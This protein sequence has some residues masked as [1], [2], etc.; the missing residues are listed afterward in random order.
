MKINFG[1]LSPLNKASQVNMDAERYGA[2]AE[3]GAGQEVARHFFQAGKASQTIAKTMSA[4]DMI[5]SDEI[6]GKEKNGRYVCESRL[7]K[8]LSKEYDLLEKRLSASRGEKTKFFAF[9]NT[10]AT[11]SSETPRCHGWMGVRFQN[12]ARGAFNDIVLHV[13]MMDPYRLQQQEALGTLGV[14]LIYA[15]FYGIQKAENFLSLLTENLKAGQIRIDVIKFRG[16]DLVSFDNQKLNLELV[17]KGLSEC[18]LFNPKMDVLNVSD[19]IYGKSV[20]VQRGHYKPPTITHVEVFKKGFEHFRKSLKN[21]TPPKSILCISEILLE[22]KPNLGECLFRIQALTQLGH[23]VL[24][25]RFKWYYELKSYL[26]RSTSNPIA[27]VVGASHLERIFEPEAYAQLSGGILE[28]LGRLLD[29]DTKLLIYPHKTKEICLTAS[30]FSPKPNSQH[31]Y[32]HFRELKQIVDISGCDESEFYFHSIDIF[33][34]AQKREKGWEQLVP[35]GVAD[36]MKKQKI[37]GYG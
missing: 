3:I 22:E 18:V 26:R 12:Q 9:A 8:M 28:G 31:L 27:I 6:Y 32:K 29:Q 1:A 36:L 37:W 34:K 7:E 2:F 23:M 33:K 19:E 16:P 35:P 5:Y 24:V 30:T 13:R 4:Y 20:L 15:A 17:E 10:V 14:G 21:E 11:G 25:S